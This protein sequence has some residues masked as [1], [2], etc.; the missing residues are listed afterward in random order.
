MFNYE[1]Y[2]K[3]LVEEKSVDLSAINLGKMTVVEAVAF[4][5]NCLIFPAI[6]FQVRK[7]WII[8]EAKDVDLMFNILQMVGGTPEG[9]IGA[10]IGY[11]IGSPQMMAIGIYAGLFS[12]YMIFF[13]LYGRG[14]MIKSLF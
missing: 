13:T 4:F 6:A 8:K 7:T 14:G 12:A 1:E 11:L 2:R 9:F 10:I 3:N 5:T